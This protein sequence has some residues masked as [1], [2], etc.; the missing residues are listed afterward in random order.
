M[1][2]TKTRSEQ[3]FEETYRRYNQAFEARD[4]EGF[5]RF[6]RDDATKIDASGDAQWNK[7]EIAELFGGLFQM[8]F[9]A[10][11]EPVKEVVA[12]HT[13]LV[14][15]DSTLTFAD[16]EEHFLTALTFTKEDGDWKILVAASTNVPS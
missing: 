11:F 13:A 15:L 6:Y 12:D 4:V 1:P 3:D 14:V 7:Q 10:R 5:L 8:D 16:F 9:T 2:L